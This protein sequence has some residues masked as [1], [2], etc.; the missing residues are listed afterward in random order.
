MVSKTAQAIIRLAQVEKNDELQRI[1]NGITLEKIGS[2]LTTLSNEDDLNVPKFLQGIFHG[3]PCNSSEGLKRRSFVFPHC[4]EIL[5]DVDL[6]TKVATE[7]LGILLFEIDKTSSDILCDLC[8]KILDKLRKGLMKNGR[9]LQLFPTILSSIASRDSLSLNDGTLSGNEYKSQMINTLCSIKWH[10][11]CV[12]HLANMFREVSLSDSELK[13]VIEKVIRMFKELDIEEIP[14]VVYQLLILCSR[15]HWLVVLEGIV[16]YFTQL[17][18]DNGSPNELLEENELHQVSSDQLRH[19]QGNVILHITFAIKRDQKL[20]KEFIKYLKSQQHQPQKILASFNLAIA[21]SIAQSHRFEEPI[22]DVLKAAVLK[23]FK[24]IQLQKASKW[25]QDNVEKMPNVSVEVLQTVKNSVFGWDYVVQGIVH[26]GFYLMD[27]FGS[28]HYV[29][30]SGLVKQITPQQE[31]C[32]LGSEILLKTFQ[33]HDVIRTEILEQI[34]NRLLTKSGAASYH[35][36]DLLKNAVSLNPQALLDS[37]PKVKEILE[38]LSCLAF[39][40]SQGLLQAIL[41]LMKISITL[42][43]SLMLVLRKSMFSRSLEARKIAVYGF[44]IVLKHFKV[45]GGNITSSQSI[46]HSSQCSSHSLSQ[47][48]VDVHSTNNGLNSGNEALCLEIIGGLRRCFNQQADVRVLLYEGLCDVLDLNS[49][50]RQS[51][52][53]IICAHFLKYY[54]EEEDILPPLKLEPCLTASGDQVFLAEP[55]AHLLCLLSQTVIVSFNEEEEEKEEVA[56]D[57]IENLNN[58][59]KKIRDILNSLTQRMKRSDLEDFQL[60]KLADY[61]MTNGVGVKNNI[62]ACIVLGVLEVLMEHSFILGECSMEACELVLELFNKYCKLSNVLKGITSSQSVKKSRQS[63]SKQIARSM[64]S[65]GAITIILEALFSDGLPSHQTSLD[66]LRNSGEFVQYVLSVTQQKLTQINDKGSCDGVKGTND[67]HICRQSTRIAR[68]LFKMVDGESSIIKKDSKII[69]QC[70]N[71]VFLVMNI[72]GNKYPAKIQKFLL[73]LDRGNNETEDVCDE[74]QLIYKYIKKFQR[75]VVTTLASPNDMMTFK[76]IPHMMNIIA[77]LTRCLKEDADQIYLVQSWI[78]RICLEHNTDITVCK[79]FVS[80]LLTLT[81]KCKSKLTCVKEISV[82]IHKQL[83]DIDEDIELNANS[84]F[85]IVNLK[86]AP[87]I[88]TILL[89]EVD[90]Q[91]EEIDWFVTKM[92]AEKTKDIVENEEVLDDDISPSM[93]TDNDERSICDRLISMIH[94]FRELVQSA[95]ATGPLSELLLKTLTKFYTVLGNLTKYYLY[96]YNQKAGRVTPSFEKLVKCSGLQ[97]SSHVYAF[98]TYVQ[99][100]EQERNG[101]DKNRTG[102]IT[103]GR[104]LKEMR[105]VPNLIY[106]L[107]QYERYLIQLSKKSKVNLMDHFKRSTARDFRINGATLDAA[108]REESTDEEEEDTGKENEEPPKKKGKSQSMTT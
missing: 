94:V 102:S 66:V 57:G 97:L 40:T 63:S 54:E 15:G 93:P 4:I 42:R 80:F 37:L 59:M 19:T 43:D 52:L 35:Y 12:I 70:L 27:T 10:P 73:A 68:V 17:N 81:S 107:E 26:L 30:D 85:T 48:Q 8:D 61:S 28:K 86:T 62:F 72:F 23:S 95:I 55:L 88:L 87:A 51:A 38:Y 65:L 64:L 89:G 69:N 29:S 56:D 21:L 41:P 105:S 83:G 45:S 22:L 7:Y 67:N 33:T 77:L 90:L 36:I 39:K 32:R 1:L 104:V 75:F 49:H 82:D 76:D 34:F 6:S 101:K 16:A 2:I 74:N 60:D 5:N 106:S 78:K 92:K 91:L 96:I 79:S 9:V 100:T 44:L 14:P 58:L 20:G 98:L 47:I 99:A 11:N 50:L 46:S 84:Y 25:I 71:G 13:F 108:L 24:N 31:S 53:E 18:C 3:S 103:K